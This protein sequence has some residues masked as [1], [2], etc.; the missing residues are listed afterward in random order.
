MSKSSPK[1][2][3]LPKVEPDTTFLES[4]QE[5]NVLL[6]VISTWQR[7]RYAPE[8]RPLRY[9][10]YFELKAIG[11]QWEEGFSVL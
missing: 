10:D 11:T 1:V 4:N 7:S 5:A 3:T 8:D 2:P 6:P 9:R